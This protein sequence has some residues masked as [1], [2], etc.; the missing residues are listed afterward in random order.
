MLGDQR[1]VAENHARGRR[2]EPREKEAGHER[3]VRDAE[4]A[5]DR[6][7]D[8]GDVI[9]GSE[10]AVADRRHRLDA[11]PVQIVKSVAIE[12]L[13]ARDPEEDGEHEIQQQE[14]T[15]KQQHQPRPRRRTEE[16][17]RVVADRGAAN[18]TPL[19]QRTAAHVEKL[20]GLRCH[21][22]DYAIQ[23]GV[24]AMSTRTPRRITPSGIGL[25][26]PY[27]AAP[28]ASRRRTRASCRRTGRADRRRR[29]RSLR[30]GCLARPLDLDGSRAESMVIGEPAIE[31]PADR[32]DAEPRRVGRV[33]AGAAGRAP[34]PRS[35]RRSRSRCSA[36]AR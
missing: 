4:E 16:V 3:G 15:G 20:L 29:A 12:N 14:R 32:A 33:R 27:F 11:E 9:A 26:A 22:A 18:T 23:V 30:P 17:I 21:E 2:R 24:I 25:P 5:L 1:D 35:R 31:R 10:I 19:D 36:S 34:T 13:R 7:D 28:C 6:D 8:I